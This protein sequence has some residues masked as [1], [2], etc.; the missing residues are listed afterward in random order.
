LHIYNLIL[1]LLLAD[2]AIN[3]HKSSKCEMPSSFKD[4]VDTATT[5]S[6]AGP[7]AFMA[8][9]ALVLFVLCFTAIML[10]AEE[11]DSCPPAWGRTRAIDLF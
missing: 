8:F 5:T 6:G 1:V 4:F 9:L 2:V 10:L 11:Y 3:L 7:A